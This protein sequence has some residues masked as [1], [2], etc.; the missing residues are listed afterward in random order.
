MDDNEPLSGGGGEVFDKDD[1]YHRNISMIGS[2]MKMMI[3]MILVMMM[4]MIISIISKL[5]AIA[6]RT[7]YYIFCMRNKPWCNPEL[8]SY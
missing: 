7:T 4:I 3:S 8:L 5:S 1:W 6:I 2:L